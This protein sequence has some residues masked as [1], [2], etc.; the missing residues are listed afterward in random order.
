VKKFIYLKKILLITALCIQFKPCWAN[1][2]QNGVD[3]DPS[4]G[5][6]E[7]RLRDN[8]GKGNSPRDV[9][10]YMLKNGANIALAIFIT[11]CLSHM[12]ENVHLVTHT[13]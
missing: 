10:Y 1:V 12:Q 6:V 7:Q 8:F 4:I 3:R 11:Y 13:L 9:A 2:D 5:V